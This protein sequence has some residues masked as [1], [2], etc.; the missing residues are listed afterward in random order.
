MAIV[1]QNRPLMFV[2]SVMAMEIVVF[3]LVENLVNVSN[4]Q[5][6]PFVIA[7]EDI[8]ETIASL[9]IVLDHVKM[10]EHVLHLT[11]AVVYQVSLATLALEFLA[12]AHFVT[13]VVHAI[14][15]REHVIVLLDIL[16]L[17]ALLSIV[18][19]L[20]NTVVHVLVPI[21]AAVLQLASVVL[22]AAAQY[23]SLLVSMVELV[24]VKTIAI[25]LLDSQEQ[26]VHLH[27]T[28]ESLAYFLW[29]YWSQLQEDL[30]LLH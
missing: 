20:V 26:L 15:L 5:L 14:T 6:L 8:S 28:L 22:H 18:L 3:H 13:T 11:F 16:V 19:Q 25:V 12:M 21:F 17:P 29:K 9:T 30:L 27:K 24:L 4:Q 1:V 2:E 10:V 23:V 7:V